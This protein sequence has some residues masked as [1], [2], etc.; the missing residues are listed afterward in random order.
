MAYG[1]LYNIDYLVTGDGGFKGIHAIEG[2]QIVTPVAFYEL[3]AA[4]N[5][6]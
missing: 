2:L 4:H 5:L 1:L 3:L 6:V